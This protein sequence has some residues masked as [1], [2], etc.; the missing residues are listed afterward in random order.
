MDLSKG[1]D[2][3][4]HNLP[5]AKLRTYEFDTKAL[6]YIKSYLDNRN[7]RVRVNINFSSSQE[8]IPGVPEGSILGPV[9]FKIFVNDLSLLVSNA[10]LSNYA[11]DNTIHP[12]GYNLE[13]EKE[14]LLDNLNKVTE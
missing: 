13:K 5:I 8:I 4:N 7:Q 12:S 6:H 2:T 10:K 14:V 1:L 3:L 11:D 9:L